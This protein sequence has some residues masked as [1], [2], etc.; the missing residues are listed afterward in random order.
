[1]DL[2]DE[3]DTEPIEGEEADHEQC[4]EDEDEGGGAMKEAMHE[5]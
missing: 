1:M 2:T 4:T 5:T 3:V